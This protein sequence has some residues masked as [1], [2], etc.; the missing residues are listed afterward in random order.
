MLGTMSRLFNDLNTCMDP[1]KML[2]LFPPLINTLLLVWNH[3]KSVLILK[4]Y[5]L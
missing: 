1:H 2:K 3:S 4:F 5:Q